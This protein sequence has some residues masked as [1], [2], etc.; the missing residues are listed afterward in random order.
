MISI[1]MPV[2]N[3][4]TY[5]LESIPSIM[6]Q[7]YMDF[8]LLCV[9]DCSD[10]DITNDILNE[11]EEKDARIKIL[12]TERNCGAGKTRNY[13]MK[14]A[15]GE[16]LLFLDAD[17]IFDKDMLEKMLY[18]IE[19]ADADMCVCGHRKVDATSGKIIEEIVP[20]AKAG[21]TDRT[22]RLHDLGE[23]GLQYWIKCSSNV[24]CKHS[25]IKRNN[26]DFLDATSYEDMYFACLCAIYASRIV[27]CQSGS[28][29]FSYRVGHLTQNTAHRHPMDTYKVISAV[30]EKA[31]A[32]K[33]IYLYNQL[34]CILLGSSIEAL[35]TS[36]FEEE[37]REYYV[38]LTKYFSE[39][40]KKILFENTYLNRRIEYFLVKEYE[41][42]WFD[43]IGDFEKQLRVRWD[44]ISSRLKSFKEGFVIWGNGK[45]GRAFQKLCHEK[46]YKDIWITDRCGVVEGISE[47]SC[48]PFLS[49]RDVMKSNLPIIA[50]NQM[51]FQSLISECLINNR[52]LIDIEQYCPIE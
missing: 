9:N 4:G 15:K 6:A 44:E 21:V 12:Y 51:I 10:D 48:F 33:D 43:Y 29:L 31:E 52:E 27:Y 18:C 5:L 28:P 14:F 42:R 7:T 30:I 22:F 20:V 19:L 26:I 46:G 41:S 36:P 16:Y 17:D 1:I 50:S 23:E 40:K 38:F 13:G 45:R 8:E 25:L 47:R 24:L 49:S 2:Y 39:N 37:K 3:A 34:I 11:L 32:N 35:R